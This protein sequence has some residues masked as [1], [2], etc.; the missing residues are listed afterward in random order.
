MKTLR[1]KP[2]V[3]EVRRIPLSFSTQRLFLTQMVKENNRL[4]VSIIKNARDRRSTLAIQGSIG[5]QTEAPAPR[6]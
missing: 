1:K 6:K 3:L 5:P 4:K 2:S